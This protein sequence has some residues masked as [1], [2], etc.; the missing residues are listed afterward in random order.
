[1]YA[2]SPEAVLRTT[3]PVPPETE[4]PE[5]GAEDSPAPAEP[6]TPT[7]PRELSLP[8]LAKL[9]AYDTLAWENPKRSGIVLGVGLGLFFGLFWLR[10]SLP[11]LI[12]YGVGAAAIATGLNVLRKRLSDDPS[13]TTIRLGVDAGTL[14]SMATRGA[15]Y[16]HAAITKV[17]IILSWS[18]IHTTAS[19]LAYGLLLGTILDV[20]PYG[21][22][23]LMFFSLFAIVPAFQMKKDEINEVFK[24]HGSPIILQAADQWMAVRREV[25]TALGSFSAESRL[26]VIAA[27][28]GLTMYAGLDFVPLLTVP[29][30]AALAMVLDD[31]AHCIQNCA[32]SHRHE[33]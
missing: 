21:A 17:E 22:F 15:D 2:A 26:L 29:R 14:R 10:V 28:I 11:S 20:L 7:A 32:S 4:A 16:V 13:D 31:A 12:I 19:V 9:P 8:D 6:A 27:A 25:D 23:F 5:H 33:E 3:P 1:M 24:T 30:I 18:D